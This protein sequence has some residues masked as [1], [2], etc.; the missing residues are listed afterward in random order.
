MPHDVSLYSSCSILFLEIVEHKVVLN[1]HFL[2]STVLLVEH[3]EYTS[4][5]ETC[6]MPKATPLNDG[7]YSIKIY[8]RLLPYLVQSLSFLWG[9]MIF[10]LTHFCLYNRGRGSAWQTSLNI[11]F[12]KEKYEITTDLP[13]GEGSNGILILTSMELDVVDV[14]LIEGCDDGVLKNIV[15][16]KK[17]SI[18]V[19]IDFSLGRKF[20]PLRGGS[21]PIIVVADEVHS[22]L[23]GRQIGDVTKGKIVPQH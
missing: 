21:I 23:G 12:M 19:F 17:T 6:K 8:M 22:M 9:L 15:I 11:I 10:L 3:V 16:G 1:N 14:T 2:Q 7:K 13:F 20:H 18:Y 4:S 5:W